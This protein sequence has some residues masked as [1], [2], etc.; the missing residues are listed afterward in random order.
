MHMYY[1]YSMGSQRPVLSSEVAFY[2]SIIVHAEFTN[3][4]TAGRSCSDCYDQNRKKGQA[5][6]LPACSS[7][8]YVPCRGEG[9]II[10]PS[11]HNLSL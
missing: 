6:K 3:F 11:Q 7:H 9:R 5:K 10:V 2:K 8:V 4:M 1:L